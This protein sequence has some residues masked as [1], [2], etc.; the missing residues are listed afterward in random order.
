MGPRERLWYGTVGGEEGLSLVGFVVEEPPHTGDDGGQ[1]VLR[2]LDG[3]LAALSQAHIE[4]P[5]EDSP[6]GQEHPGLQ[7][8]VGQLGRTVGQAF[9]S[10]PND[11]LD[12]VGQ[13][14]ADL[15]GAHQHGGMGAGSQLAAPDLR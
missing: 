3:N 2:E 9:T 5:K 11:Q 4:P 14:L 7:D 13:D 15:L 12:R 10:G 6:A 1:G 8:V